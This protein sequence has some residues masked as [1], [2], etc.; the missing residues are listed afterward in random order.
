MANTVAIGLT[1]TELLESISNR[2][3]F[4]TSDATAAGGLE[5]G[6]PPMGLSDLELKSW[7][8]DAVR[9][10]V[11]TL[12]YQKT[13][14]WET[15]GRA[16]YDKFL[17]APTWPGEKSGITIGVGFDLG[18]HEPNEIEAAWGDKLPRSQLD[19]L[20][21]THG[22][23]A[24]TGGQV[25][26]A[27]LKQMA[28]ELKD[29]RIPWET[30]EVVFVRATLPK[31]ARLV[32]RHVANAA[33]LHPHVFGTL[34]SLVFNRGPSFQNAGER[35]KEMRDIGFAMAD[36]KFDA[37]PDHIVAMKHLWPNTRGLLKRRDEEADLCRLGL[38]EQA[39][40]AT[41][42]SSVPAPG[43]SASL[44]GESREDYP[45][46]DTAPESSDLPLPENYKGPSF[47]RAD[48]KWA[49]D[50]LAPDYR[51]IADRSLSG[52][53]FAISA[54]DIELLIKANRYAPIRDNKR[55]LFGL[56]GASLDGD[57]MQVDLP[58]LHLRDARP[59]H[60]EF[61]CV[62]GVLNLETRTLSGFV[63][64][65]VPNANAVLTGWQLHAT[66]QSEM[67]GNL[68]T[69]GCYPY[70][71]GAHGKREVP[72]CF[73]QGTSANSEDRSWVVVLR[74]LKDVSYDLDDYWNVC[75]PH[76]NMHPAFLA[77]SF[78]SEG[79][80]TV[81]GLWTAGAHT[82]DFAAL[83]L[84][85]GKAGTG[86]AGSRF[87]YMLITGLE[88]A[89]AANLR[90]R[91][92]A[93]DPVIVQ[94][95]LGR[96][97]QGSK[98]LEVAALQR[99]LK[100]PETGVLD[101]K[102]RMALIDRQI[103]EKLPTDGIYT[104]Q[105]DR[106]LA[107]HAF[108]PAGAAKSFQVAAA[109]T[110]EVSASASH[111]AAAQMT[112]LLRAS[113]ESLTY[114]IGLRAQLAAARPELAVERDLGTAGAGAPEFGFADLA[115]AGARIFE[116]AQ[117]DVC[118]ILCGGR[119][120]DQPFRNELGKVVSSAMTASRVASP[121]DPPPTDAAHA[122][123]T[124]L[125]KRLGV[126]PTIAEPLA[127]LIVSQ[128]L[129]PTIEETCRAWNARSKAPSVVTASSGASRAATESLSLAQQDLPE[130][131]AF[132]KYA[133][134]S[135]DD[136]LAE[137]GRQSE[138]AS[139][140]SHEAARPESFDLSPVFGNAGQSIYL[141][142]ERQLYEL[143]CGGA[144]SDEV[145]ENLA[146]MGGI[147]PNLTNKA[148]AS[149]A[150]AMLLVAKLAIM[151]AVAAPL[152]V[153]VVAKVL[154]EG[155]DQGCRLWGKSIG[156]PAVTE[157]VLID[158]RAV[159][160]NFFMFSSE[161]LPAADVKAAIAQN[162]RVMVGFDAGGIPRTGPINVKSFQ[163]ARDLK[164]ELEI[165]VEGPGGPTGKK[166]SDDELERVQAAAATVGID[167]N[168]PRWRQL[169]W[170]T[171]GWR[172]FTFQQLADYKKQGFNAAEIDNI[173][174]VI[175]DEEELL[176][177]FKDYAAQHQADAVPQL[178]MKNLSEHEMA[179]VAD[180]VEARVL[181]RKMFS[182]FHICE[183]GTGYDAKKIDAISRRMGIRTL[184]SKDT[185]AYDANGEFRYF[186]EF[187]AAFG[188]PAS[189]VS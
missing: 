130:T 184:L 164:A 80:Q 10:L 135:Q 70:V 117:A 110:A 17:G 91:G 14:G 169:H 20:L 58:E 115:S 185:N 8:D 165:Y 119:P 66:K 21:A 157:S 31:Y 151:P 85:V 120:E 133:E 102:D 40:T 1:E 60:L 121:D 69:T 141:R 3:R 37:L 150:L 52:K 15:G 45:I 129:K 186:A 88:A 47:V 94:E 131:D 154:S 182:D 114:E 171:G 105:M 67:R 63:A 173:G 166:W 24:G 59:D 172:T 113:P 178:V 42:A 46:D 44:S 156:A 139:R 48:V 33:E 143:I 41:I 29:I 25:Q 77:E 57:R 97:R 170:D 140:A 179:R 26:T 161:V 155:L 87:D 137:I 136:L 162:K 100:R 132:A 92:L 27:L 90:I 2:E 81:R 107:I 18:Y 93:S 95:Q 183:A 134:L 22:K 152:A 82:G 160:A 147:D 61:R 144:Q 36:R 30:A 9:R 72:G 103:E 116:W 118:R 16:Y 4:E 49:N 76:D 89:I 174:R 112:A 64:S 123:A 71:I 6:G 32:L 188:Q 51:H 111:A 108:E 153:Y 7:S 86:G 106:T 125:V 167:T 128:V 189:A 83:K 176:A 84:A 53:R 65:T 13:L 126:L 79:C 158:G 109:E 187:D 168:K 180:A 54:D 34:F 142:L 12:A 39:K 75:Q 145:R 43:T 99:A 5:A 124:I 55:I 62:I 73:L 19:R 11:S 159:P 104:P 28:L 101:A 181:P 122:I 163:T 149:H 146:K 96:L 56:R 78:S 175:T 148:A 38:A 74:S 98:G 50:D 35:Y 138:R 127:A 23:N 177:F 68:L